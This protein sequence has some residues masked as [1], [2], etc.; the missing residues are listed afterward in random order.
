MPERRN[1]LFLMTDQHRVDT[2]RCYGNDAIQTPNLDRIGAEGTRFDRFYTPTAICTPARASLMTGQHPF[3]HGMLFNPERSGGAQSEIPDHVGMLPAPLRAA[4]YNVG[5]VGKWHIGRERGPEYYGMDGEHLPGAL[6]P[7]DHP[8]YQRWLADSAHPP[9]AVT[10]AEFGVAP[11]GSGRGHLLAG[12]LRQPVEATMEWFLTERATDLLKRYG[13]DHH[14]D[15]RPFWLT[16]SWFGPHL[17]YLIPDKYYDLYHPADVPLPPSMAETFDGKPEVQRRY[18]EYWSADALGS[19][20][21]R[22]LI[23]VYW[24]YVTMIDH[25]VGMLLDTLEE[26]DLTHNTAVVFTADHGEFTGAH[27]LH[28]KGPAMYEDI[29]RIPALFRVPGMP[30]QSR[31]EFASLVDIAPT[32][33]DLAGLPPMQ[34]ADGR[35]LLP[36]LRGE[37]VTD[38]PKQFVAEFHGHHFPYS[39]RMIR[40]ERYKLVFNPESSNELYDLRDDPH[41]LHNVYQAP[42]YARI[43]ER[44][45]RGLYRELVDRADPAYSWMSYMSAVGE[46]RAPDVD[47]IADRVS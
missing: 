16:C 18:S 9:F 47:G 7:F 15:G 30:A 41:E 25:C 21:W 45:E 42:T 33:L 19:E 36:L 44:L 2:L 26:L 17:P 23:A 27:R 10:D 20:R 13:A 28:D 31:N 11:N 43:R 22:K 29:Y 12:R 4:G 5:H 14:R 6:N 35:S 32:I 1:V 34:P 8:S 24:G 39:Q 38:W 46:D 37:Q 40:D 3:R